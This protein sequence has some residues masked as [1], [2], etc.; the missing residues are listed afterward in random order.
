MYEIYAIVQ[1]IFSF[2]FFYPALLS[3]SSRNL[4]RKHEHWTCIYNCWTKLYTAHDDG[5][6]EEEIQL[7]EEYN[8]PTN[9]IINIVP[10]PTTTT[11][12]NDMKFIWFNCNAIATFQMNEQTKQRSVIN[13][14]A[15]FIYLSCICMWKISLMS[16]G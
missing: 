8:P 15:H 3:S 6:D 16:L 2:F 7:F 11:K 12:N 10:I 13:C 9:A 14:C 1:I 4:P 5:D